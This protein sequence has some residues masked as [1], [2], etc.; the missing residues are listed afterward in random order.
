[1][2]QEALAKHYVCTLQEA[3]QLVKERDEYWISNCGCREDRGGCGR[4][5]LE[6][7]L[8]FCDIPAS[9]SGKHRASAGE[10]EEILREAADAHLVPRPF[11][12]DERTGIDGICFC[13]D[14]CCAYFLDPTEPC[15]KGAS[16]EHTRLESCTRCG[17]CTEV[18][19]FGARAMNQDSLVIETE[20]CFGCGLC[21]D[22]CPENCIGISARSDW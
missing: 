18:C 2:R 11:R 3:R 17:S 13:C 4:S 22:V 6:L 1:M 8:M 14:D 15:D 16:I 9:G 5:R 10:V 21:A 20:K 12:N 19:H 7:C